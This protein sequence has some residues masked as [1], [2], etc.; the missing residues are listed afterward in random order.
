MDER[1]LSYVYS[2]RC[3]DELEHFEKLS[4][5]AQTN[6]E[7]YIVAVIYESFIK[8]GDEDYITARLLAQKGM[9]RAFFWA[10]SQALEK[11][12]KAFLLMRGRPVKHFKGHPIAAL[13]R[14]ACSVDEQLIS[15]DTKPHSKIKYHPSS[16]KSFKEISMAE[17]IKDIEAQGSPDNRYNSFGVGFNSGYLFSLDSFVFFLR[18]KIGVPPIQE[19]LKK[20]DNDLVEAF[21]CYNPW[22]TPIHIE[23]AE[24]PNE[25]FN[26]RLS[27][28]VTTLE[29]LISTKPLY[30]SD[31]ALQWLNKKMK[32]P[33]KVKQFM[34]ES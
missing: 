5:E 21:Y 25:N 31:L 2:F 17:F 19:T 22:F 13:L 33:E 16:E 32:L 7:R 28:S 1:K 15:I 12:L 8:P 34:K 18:Q 4:N 14:E 20:L 9:Y 23:L 27:G 10:A 11:Y 26:L 3:E 30:C 6:I 24:I 29:R